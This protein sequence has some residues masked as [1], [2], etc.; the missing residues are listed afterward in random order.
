MTD[1]DLV[2]LSLY[3]LVAV[4]GMM[5]AGLVSVIYGD[6]LFGWVHRFK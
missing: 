3:M 5:G 2:K 6:R 1:T 4:V